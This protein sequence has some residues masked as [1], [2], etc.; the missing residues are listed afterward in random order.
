MV[1]TTIWP[2][3]P[4]ATPTSRKS[5]VGK[6][7]PATADWTVTGTLMVV[8]EDPDCPVK[9]SVKFPTAKVE[10]AVKVIVPVPPLKARGNVV[11][12]VMPAG[13]FGELTVA[14]PEPPDALTATVKVLFGTI[15][16]EPGVTEIENGIPPPPPVPPPPLAPPPPQE[17]ISNENQ[18]TTTNRVK[19]LDTSRI[20]LREARHFSCGNTCT[21]S[22]TLELGES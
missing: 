12:E 14:A 2:E 13:R 10:A 4:I 17:A 1:F 7:K 9:D 20:R 5:G 11:V 19:R 6:K 8:V 3:P 18:P 15:T 21:S 16:N 22:G